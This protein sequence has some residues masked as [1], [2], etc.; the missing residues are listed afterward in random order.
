MANR[1]ADWLRQAEADL[2]HARHARSAGDY[3][4]ACFASH[5]A[6][7]KAIK[8]VILGRSA[9]AW[10]HSVTRL[11]AMLDTKSAPESASL[12][13]AG[14]LLDRHYIPTRYP[15]NL[16]EGAPT[17]FYRIADA[18]EAIRAAEMIYA[19]CRNQAR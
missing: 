4:W 9:E 11:V 17:D 12:I 14:R 13:D 19:H 7:E 1:S 8:G 6:G 10:G 16:P 18:D 5:Q 3:D 2:Q 15:D